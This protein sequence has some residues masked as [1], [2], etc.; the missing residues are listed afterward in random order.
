MPDGS[1]M[2]IHK[3]WGFAIGNDDEMRKTADLLTTVTNSII[4]TYV[5]R[6]GGDKEEISQMVADETWMGAQECLDKGFCTHVDEALQVAASVKCPE[7]FMNLPRELKPQ[8]IQLR[9]AQTEAR[10]WLR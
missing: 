1:F 3:A 4:D 5:S 7:I 10:K 9:A 2:M 8:V 6:T